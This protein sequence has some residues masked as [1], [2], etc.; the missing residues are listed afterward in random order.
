MNSIISDSEEERMCKSAG[1]PAM[2]VIEIS[3]DSD[4]DVCCQ[5]SPRK[6]SP[7][8]QGRADLHNTGVPPNNEIIELTDSDSDDS[9]ELPNLLSPL[10]K[11]PTN[12]GPSRSMFA[13]PP[14]SRKFIP[15]YVDASDDDSD[16]GSILV[17][18]DPHGSRK[19][20]HSPS[21]FKGIPRI[22][23]PAAAGGLA[24]EPSIQ[25]GQNSPEGVSSTPARLLKKN[26]IITEPSPSKSAAKQP[27]ISKKAQVAEDQARRERYATELFAELNRTVF[28]DGLPRETQLEWS[29][30]LLT[31]AGRARWH[32]SREG[33]HTTKI[34]LAAKI[35]DC[36]E[37]I[38]NTLSH[39]MCHLACWVIDNNPQEGHGHLFKSWAN[40]VMRKRPDIHISTRHN[41]EISYPYEWKCQKC[42]KIYGRYSKSI[43]PDECV[44]GACK[45]GKLIPLFAQRMPRTP[46]VSR[47]AIAE[48]Q[49][50]PRSKA[51]GPS[52][53]GAVIQQTS[54]PLVDSLSSDSDDEDLSG[55]VNALKGVAIDA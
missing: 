46:K 39:E 3:S 16:D 26:V 49:G 50:S 28:G 40:K 52:R 29:K 31:T 55:L 37:R 7:I 21:L 30:R 1:S 44:C 18:N 47:M 4:E 22:S 24:R 17:L 27:R 14:S 12:P 10:V 45:V 43:R 34:E 2:E 32:R 41:Y 53:S 38:R 5:A 54:T 25:A 19:Q 11:K 6:A 35:L 33:V 48:P 9:L 8:H 42:S 36:N 20:I 13:R 23:P 15:L 51:A